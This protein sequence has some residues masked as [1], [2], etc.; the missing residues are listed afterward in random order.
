MG[1]LLIIEFGKKRLRQA[2]EVIGV[3]VDVSEILAPKSIIEEATLFLK[4]LHDTGGRV[5]IQGFWF[6][7]FAAN[8]SNRAHSQEEA[9]D[10]QQFHACNPVRRQTAAAINNC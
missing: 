5:W 4:P 3:I 10:H 7:L 6:G 9:G 8:Q 2:I 1:L